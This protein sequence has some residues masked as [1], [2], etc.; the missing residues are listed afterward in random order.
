MEREKYNKGDY[1]IPSVSTCQEIVRLYPP[2]SN[3]GTFS[4]DYR[5]NLST[6]S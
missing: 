1:N 5:P 4:Y 6:L 3:F 2:G